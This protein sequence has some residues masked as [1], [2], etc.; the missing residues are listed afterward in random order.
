MYMTRQRPDQAAFTVDTCASALGVDEFTLLSRIQMGEINPVRASSGEIKIPESEMERLAP[1][2]RRGAAH[3]TTA[4]P[5]LS[6]R[7]MGIESHLGL[8]RNGIRPTLYRVPG[9]QRFLTEGEIEGYRAA[10]GA[11]AKEVAEVEDFKKQLGIERQFPQSDKMEIDTAQTGRWEVREALLNLNRSEIVL[12]QRGNDFAVIERFEEES[13]YAQTNGSAQILLQGNNAGEL[14][15][16]FQANARHTLAFMASNATAKAQ[17]IVWGYFQE[18]K[19]ELVMEA[20]SERCQQAAANQETNS[21]KITQS[22]NRGMR[23]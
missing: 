9:H 5:R 11:V 4:L 18:H 2:S 12:C 15:S 3:E 10:Y 14:K 19:P 22:I 7:S 6:D 20:I 8:Q 23:V 1:A 13:P 21:R 17:G 16:E